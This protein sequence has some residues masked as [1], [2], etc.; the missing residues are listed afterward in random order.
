MKND[1][2]T[3]KPIAYVRSDYNEKFGV[4]RQ[5]G[6]VA[7]LEQAVVIEPAFRNGDALRGIEDFTHIWLI[8]GF[9]QT[10]LNM[11][12]EPVKWYPT[13]RPPRLGGSARKGVWATR[14]PYRPNS[15]AMSCVRLI[16][17]EREG[18]P[19]SN[20]EEI[21][22]TTDELAL[23]VSGAD[24]VNGTPVYD[25]KPYIPYADSHPE[26]S[27]GFTDLTEFT[28]LRVEFPDE[29]LSLIEENKRAGLISVL[30]SDPRGAYEKQP[31]YTYGMSFGS[32]D[33]RFTVNGD[34]L[35]VT[36]VVM[37]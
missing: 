25:I 28:C 16:R 14:S 20:T 8:W 13:V 12:A 18:K 10:R 19:V 22:E 35:T 9:S 24:I 5:S 6:L 1:E 36:E 30:E 3:I 7:E 26:A 11:A 2:Y 33:I 17:I 31:G 21:G 27:G 37:I 4:P 23:I 34:I 15:L 29:L 32:W